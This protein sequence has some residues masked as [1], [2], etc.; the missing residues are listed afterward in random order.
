MTCLFVLIRGLMVVIFVNTTCCN[1]FI[2]PS[3][4]VKR[5]ENYGNKNI[6]KK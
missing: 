1:N 5:L 2:I 3:Y 6:K 4:G